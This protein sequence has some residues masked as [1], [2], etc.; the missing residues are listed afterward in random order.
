MLPVSR[1]PGSR[2]QNVLR[3]V[4][5]ASVWICLALQLVILYNLMMSSLTPST[6]TYHLAEFSSS[7]RPDTSENTTPEDMFSQ[8]E[9]GGT[10]PEADPLQLWMDNR[11]NRWLFESISYIDK[12][13][14]NEDEKKL[15]RRSPSDNPKP[16]RICM[17]VL[18]NK[19]SL[20]FELMLVSS[21]MK[22][23]DH[24]DL[25]DQVQELHVLN[26]ER[27]NE[28]Y[29]AMDT[30]RQIPFV[31]VHDM[32]VRR[33]H[34]KSYS[35]LVK[36]QYDDY[37]DALKICAGS[38][39]EWN[40]IFEADSYVSKHFLE[41]FN[42][43][44]SS[45]TEEKIAQ[46]GWLSL[47]TGSW[48]KVPPEMDIETRSDYASMDIETP[49]EYSLRGYWECY[50]NI[51]KAYHTKHMDAIL[52]WVSHEFVTAMD[53]WITCAMLSNMTLVASSVFPSL[54]QHSGFGQSTHSTINNHV[55][56]ADFSFVEKPASNKVISN[57]NDYVGCFSDHNTWRAMDEMKHDRVDTID[58]CMS[59]CSGLDYQYAG[60]Q[61]GGECWCGSQYSKYGERWASVCNMDCTNDS[62]GSC[63]GILTLSVYR[64]S[65]RSS[66]TPATLGCFHDQIQDR[67]MEHMGPRVKQLAECTQYCRDQNYKF[68][69]IEDAEECFC[70]NSYRKHGR[71]AFD[72]LCGRKCDIGDAQCGGP[73]LLSVYATYVDDQRS[74][75]TTTPVQQH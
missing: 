69:G 18:A 20:P 38:G 1:P 54:V 56:I 13:S 6:S 16:P 33:G 2:D 47:Y 4:M 43:I 51:A 39:A 32:P 12:L 49:T 36:N 14:K 27:R 21:L 48:A 66:S 62:S 46:T 60:L 9:S 59:Y 30:L 22:G 58:E 35:D 17:A 29:P 5:I 34:P 71:L 63:G 15:W 74:S 67:A 42:R 40:I 24:V 26:C 11:R 72:S 25:L 23:N 45:W 55:P 53:T 3:T 44:T 28:S 7:V 10:L 61:W 68:A 75:H 70:G 73:N 64:T 37:G 52:K 50:G 8:D 57:R 31:T 41:N 65:I 19:R